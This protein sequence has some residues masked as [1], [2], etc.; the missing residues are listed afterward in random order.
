M[1]LRFP[2]EES[3]TAF[4]EEGGRTV[5][6]HHGDPDAEWAAATGGV[7]V[8]DRSHRAQWR[9][10]GKQPLEMLSG[11][12]TGRMPEAPEE[13]ELGVMAG[14]AS[15]HAVLTPKGK[16]L[17]DLRLWREPSP[18]GEVVRADV[19]AGA[20]EGLREH[21]GRF[22]PPRLARLEDQT[23]RLG[24]ITL[25]GPAAAR[26][27]SGT[28]FGLRVQEGELEG[29][30]EGDFRLL[31]ASGADE[32]LIM[33][34]GQLSEPAF[35][36]MGEREVLRSVW[37]L[38]TDTGAEP[39]GLDVWNALRVEAG[40]PAW[41][42]E[43]GPDVI[44]VEAGIQ[45]RAID[46]R[47]GC[48]TGQEVIVRIRDRGHVNRHLRRL[49]LDPGHPLPDRDSELYSAEGKVV[50]GITT[51]VDS[52]RKGLLALGYVRRQVEPGETV[53]VG[54]PDGPEARVEALE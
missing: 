52:P 3:G 6:R 8:R 39:L 31:G 46:S 11:I 12:V 15:Y 5:I 54:S 2:P 35:D 24:M 36:V 16:M 40:R 38:L 28:A 50:G 37:R 42:R 48:Y 1:T 44:P 32:L 4:A 33:R 13:A 34:S 7:A 17:A 29:M 23:Q 43:L 25:V 53:R 19:P 9:F 45:D 47:K 20:V 18:Q 26:A 27:A 21:L 49:V 30:A 22:L 41:G 10:T 51:P 14:R